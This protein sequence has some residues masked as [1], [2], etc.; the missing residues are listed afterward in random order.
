[1]GEWQIQGSQK[2]GTVVVVASAQAG[3]TTIVDCSA[4]VK[5]AEHKINQV[6]DAVILDCD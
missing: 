4:D 6:V 2:W 5:G 1:M 3:I